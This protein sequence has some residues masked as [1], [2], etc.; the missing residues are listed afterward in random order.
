M[1]IVRSEEDCVLV[2]SFKCDMKFAILSAE[3]RLYCIVMYSV[4]ECLAE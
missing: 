2:T 4:L 1:L 3:Y